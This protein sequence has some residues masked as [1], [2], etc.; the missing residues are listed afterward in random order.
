MHVLR[1]R[2]FHCKSFEGQAWVT[3]MA[4]LIHLR[5]LGSLD[6]Y[7]EGGTY[8]CWPVM[9]VWG[10]VLQYC[11]SHSSPGFHPD[12]STS[13]TL[14]QNGFSFLLLSLHLLLASPPT[15]LEFKSIAQKTGN[16]GAQHSYWVIT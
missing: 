2:Q 3:L 16:H 8:S 14:W 12:T 9:S 5:R 7:W 10:W 15:S 1:C 11:T 13:L 6:H 4:I